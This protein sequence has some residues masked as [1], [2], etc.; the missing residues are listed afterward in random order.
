M[1][2]LSQ[3]Y[4]MDDGE[5]GLPLVQLKRALRGAAFVRGTL[6][7][8]GAEKLVEDEECRRLIGESDAISKQITDL[9]RTIRGSQE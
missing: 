2:P 6:F 9:L 8:A 1:L 5:A 3:P 4:E 7:A